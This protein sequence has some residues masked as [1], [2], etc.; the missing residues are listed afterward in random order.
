M[1]TGSVHFLRL[2]ELEFFPAPR[3]E[4]NSARK[5]TGE[6]TTLG[7]KCGQAR[8]HLVC[9]QMCQKKAGLL[10]TDLDALAWLFS[11]A[12]PECEPLLDS[13]FCDASIAASRA[14][15]EFT[16]VSRNSR[17]LQF[18]IVM[19]RTTFQRRPFHLVLGSAS[20]AA[21]ASE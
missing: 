17:Q 14:V 1:G 3:A 21:T 4:A 9:Q 19:I 7:K 13:V 11:C 5:P 8:C 6:T 2:Q 20:H 12:D 15:F 18:F 16:D 10:A